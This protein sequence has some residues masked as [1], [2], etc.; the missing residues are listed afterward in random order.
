MDTSLLPAVVGC[1][2]KSSLTPENLMKTSKSEQAKKKK[3]VYPIEI[4]VPKGKVFLEI[5]LEL[6]KGN[7]WRVGCQTAS[8]IVGKLIL[9]L[10]TQAY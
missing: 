3:K 5:F 2:R 4:T 7:P 6:L 1:W 9:N 8:W 10:K